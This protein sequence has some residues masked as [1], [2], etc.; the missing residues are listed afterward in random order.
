M[1]ADTS[2]VA[3]RLLLTLSE[4]WDGLQRNDVDPTNRGL[5]LSIDY[6]G[7]YT[8][9]SAGAGSRPR[10]I[11]EWNESVRH[12]RVVRC[13][14]WPGFDATISSTVAFVRQEASKRGL[15]DVVDAAF[16]KACQEPISARRTVV[17]KPQPVV[18]REPIARR[19]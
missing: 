7:G 5:H 15:A 16:L 4:L 1:R 9:I 12:L 6:L 2:D 3:F 10:L 8:R 17:P 11:V 19:A 13:E 18:P 14:D